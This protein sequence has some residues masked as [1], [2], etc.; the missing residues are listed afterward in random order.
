[1]LALDLGKSVEVILKLIDIGGK[2][3]VM[4][5][6]S[7]IRTALHLACKIEDMSLHIISSQLIEIGG[8]ELLMISDQFGRT[9]LHNA[10][11]NRNMSLDVVLKMIEVGGRELLL[12]SP[13]NNG[14]TALYYACWHGD[15]SIAIVSKLIEVGGKELVMKSVLNEYGVTALHGACGRENPSIVIVSKL[16]ELGGREL[17]M[18][19]EKKGRTALHYACENKNMAQEQIISKLIEVGGRELLMCE[20]IEGDIALHYGY[21]RFN[22][23]ASYNDSFA[24]MIKECIMANIGGEF[25]IGGLFHVA[26][27][28][29]RREIYRI[30]RQISPT[31]AEA[32]ESLQQ[33]HQ[34]PLLHAAIIAKAPSYVILDIINRFE[35]SVSKVDS[36]NR[37]PIE[38]A[39]QERRDW[40]DGLKQIVAATVLVAVEQQHPRIIQLAA[41]YGLKW[42][43]QM[44]ELAEANG[45][46]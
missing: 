34:P 33:G 11:M 5:N 45:T 37:Y 39:F 23:N 14:G 1:M 36:L 40:N 28:K 46:K 12:T 4:E 35:Y 31:L 3:L 44:K 24:F 29:V 22:H 15:A 7:S 43:H 27:K 17:V 25:G 26:R 20:N 38:I 10:C 8:R 9:A 18:M 42:R 16:I 30:W 13:N 19:R 6:D 32:I 2:E 21:F 41:Q